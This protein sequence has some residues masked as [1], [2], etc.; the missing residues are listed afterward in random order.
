MRMEDSP[1]LNVGG[2]IHGLASQTKEKG[3]KKTVS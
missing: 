1:T 3:K 2:A